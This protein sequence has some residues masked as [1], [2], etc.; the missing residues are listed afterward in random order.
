MQGSSLVVCEYLKN[1]IR[2]PSRNADKNK[3]NKRTEVVS[4]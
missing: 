3:K 4:F 2:N 1:K